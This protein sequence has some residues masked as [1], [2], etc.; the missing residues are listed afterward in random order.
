M[1]DVRL[2]IKREGVTTVV[3]LD[4]TT[5]QETSKLLRGAIDKG[6][7]HLNSDG[8][9]IYIGSEVIDSSIFIIEELI[10]DDSTI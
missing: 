3:Y 7:Y 10:E 5:P 4:N 1:N 6:F 8:E 2:N 9:A